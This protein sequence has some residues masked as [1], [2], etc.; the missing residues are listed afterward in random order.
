MSAAVLVF[1]TDKLRDALREVCEAV[2][3]RNTMEILSNVLIEAREDGVTL[4]TSD[5]DRLVRREVQVESV[6]QPVRFTLD[7]LRLAAVVGALPNGSQVTIEYD[8]P[9][10]LVKSGRSRT[11]FST[12][13][14]ED[15]PLI[16]HRDPPVTFTMPAAALNE[17]FGAVRFSIS[18]EE[19]RYY[20]CG[21]FLHA[22]GETLRFATTDGHRLSRLVLPLPAGAESLPDCIVPTKAVDI[23][24]KLAEARSDSDVS[25]TVGDMKIAFTIGNVSLLSKLIDGTFPDY[26][27][28][29]PS[30]TKVEAIVDREALADAAGR[31]FVVTN[32]KIRAAKLRFES[33]RLTIQVT[34]NEHGE[35]VD[36]VPCEFDQKQP[37]EVGFNLRYMQQALSALEVDTVRFA[38]TDAEAPCILTSV[39][40]GGL[41]L[42]LMPM[43]VS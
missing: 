20:L 22:A 8:A 17:A 23:V 13:P 38:M 16:A 9:A 36:E 40:P 15:F 6:S 26:E 2:E 21:T 30:Q 27:R 34:S 19:T 14:A 35:A 43:R 28:V 41:T 12:R 18:T 24:R 29:I 11:R 33:E 37:F 4:T 25:I 5:L 1:E 32:D 7:A 3:R 10:A 42:I 39:P 31:V